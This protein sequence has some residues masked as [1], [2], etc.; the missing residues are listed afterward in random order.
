MPLDQHP[1]DEG[2]SAQI[3]AALERKLTERLGQIQERLDQSVQ[4]RIQ[5]DRAF[6]KDTIGVAFKVAG[7]AVALVV[8]LLGI[9]GWKTFADVRKAMVDAATQK[10]QLYFDTQEGKHI[11]D[12]AIDRSVLNSYLIL[13]QTEKARLGRFTI[14]DYDV[15]R[16]LNLVKSTDTDRA[17]F[18]SAASVLIYASPKKSS[19]KAE[20][21]EA[22]ADLIAAKGK[23]K[24]W[25]ESN[26]EKRCLLLENL[27]ETRFSEGQ[28]QNACRDLLSD[29]AAISPQSLA[30]ESAA[31]TYLGTTQDKDAS[32][33]L[34]ELAEKGKELG[35]EAL[36]ALA[37][38]DSGNKVLARWIGELKEN[39][40]PSIEKAATALVLSEGLTDTETRLKVVDFAARHCRLA[41]S[42]TKTVRGGVKRQ[43]MAIDPVVGKASLPFE[44]TFV[45]NQ[46]GWSAAVKGL[47]KKYAQQPNL[48]DFGRVVRWLTVKDYGSEKYQLEHP[49]TKIKFRPDISVRIMLGGNAAIKLDSGEIVDRRA[50]PSGVMLSSADETQPGKTPGQMMITWVDA[51]QQQ[52][53]GNLSSFENAQDLEFKPNN[54]GPF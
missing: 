28:V 53:Q 43:L 1:D 14:D 47:L 8:V 7:F 46:D 17:T 4:Q 12:S 54:T 15:Q 37:K 45:V 18:G 36:N 29:T 24:K 39:S 32:D 19:I 22:F 20:V 10:A 9:L 25:I 13:M 30:I 50:A 34:E 52:R 49:G 44:T 16:L 2:T 6:I 23:D 42:L 26:F 31:I 51:Q 11:I 38:I 40:N 41:S 5:G 33:K 48:D 3:D 27:N 35:A 21:G